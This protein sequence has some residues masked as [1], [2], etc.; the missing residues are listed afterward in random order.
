[1]RTTL[2]IDDE[3]LSFAKDRA[4]VTG[5]SL[6][7]VV[8]EALREAAKPREVEIK[9]SRSGFPYIAAKPGSRKVTSNQVAAA[10]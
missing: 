1:M 10:N 6:G 7:A 3:A 4:R 2:N 9:T 8:S 5:K